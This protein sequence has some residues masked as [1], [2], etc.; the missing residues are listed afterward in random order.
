MSK[1][2]VV[3]SA[4]VAKRCKIVVFNQSIE[5]ATK[6]ERRAAW[7]QKW[8]KRFFFCLV[9]IDVHRSTS[10]SARYTSTCARRTVGR[11]CKNLQK[12][13]KSAKCAK[14][15]K[16]THELQA[17]CIHHH[18]PSPFSRFNL[19]MSDASLLPGVHTALKNW[20]L[21]GRL[22]SSLHL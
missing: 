16:C 21:Q 3:C 1:K 10:T 14:H 11:R 22:C 4:L 13:A 15:A 7:L 9:V 17:W 19:F 20:R 18:L 12:S 8:V 6:K 5:K 2:C